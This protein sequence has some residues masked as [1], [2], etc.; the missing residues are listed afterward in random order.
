ME[1]EKLLK[2]LKKFGLSEYECKVYLS[3][4]LL[5][6]SKVGEIAK[7]SNVPLSKIYEILRKLKD[8]K[9]I[10]TLGIKKPA[11]YRALPPEI[12]LNHQIEREEKRINQLKKEIKYLAKILKPVGVREKII[13][14]F[15]ISEERGKKEFILQLCKMFKKAR[16]YIY[17]VTKDFTLTTE[18]AKAVKDCQK[19][20]IQIRTIA[21]RKIDKK[22]YE[23]AKWFYENGVDIRIFETSVHPRIIVRGEEILIR[24]DPTRS[25]KNELPFISY[26]SEDESLVSVFDFY[27]KTLWKVSKPVTWI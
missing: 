16:N 12:A 26:W 23:R 11:F 20:R 13:R 22:I 24:L 5:G 27:V 17:V 25:E 15:W 18:V 19:R 10:K 4:C 6:P 8:K 3:L 9:M 21:T 2:K 14:G 1:K 7:E